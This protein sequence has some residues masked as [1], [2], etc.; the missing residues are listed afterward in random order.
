MIYSGCNADFDSREDKADGG[1]EGDEET[2]VSE[3]LG[4]SSRYKWPMEV[5]YLDISLSRLMVYIIQT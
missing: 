1:Q 5:E 4:G 2:E 3:R